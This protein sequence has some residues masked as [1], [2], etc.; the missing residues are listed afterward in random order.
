M[1]KTCAGALLF[2][3]GDVRDVQDEIYEEI[4]GR[5]TPQLKG[6]LDWIRDKGSYQGTPWPL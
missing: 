2:T 4:V 1:T 5:F 6:A 3:V